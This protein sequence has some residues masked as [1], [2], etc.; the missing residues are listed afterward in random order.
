MFGRNKERERSYKPKYLE[1]EV[2]LRRRVMADGRSFNSLELTAI[3]ARRESENEFHSPPEG[4][5][6][7]LTLK[8]LEM[9]CTHVVIG[10]G[11]YTLDM[12]L[13]GNH[14]EIRGS[15]ENKRYVRR[16]IYYRDPRLKP[17][18]KRRK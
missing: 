10:D 8:Q 5:L 15:E 18:K 6:D 17:S 9:G 3:G 4:W 14:F 13:N 11:V 16:H 1:V 7:D 2:E 12:T